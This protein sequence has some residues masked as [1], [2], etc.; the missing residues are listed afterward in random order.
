MIKINTISV[1]P[2]NKDYVE[3]FS[4]DCTKTYR[5]IEVEGISL[6]MYCD[7]TASTPG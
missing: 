3:D 4:T 5:K 1:V 6:S 7:K 2:T